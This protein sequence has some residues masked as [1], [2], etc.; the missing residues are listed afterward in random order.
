MLL[1]ASWP[2]LAVA[3]HERGLNVLDGKTYP[4][5]PVM[6]EIPQLSFQ[7]EPRLVTE[8]CGLKVPQN[9]DCENLCNETQCPPL[10]D[11]QTTVTRRGLV[12]SYSPEMRMRMGWTMKCKTHGLGVS[13]MGN[14][15]CIL[16]SCR[17]L[18]LSKVRS[19]EEGV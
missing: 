19:W 8:W 17:K 15:P 3:R 16:W 1:I 6:L 7:I 9:F 11:L 12:W 10:G 14:C 18:R 13:A 2:V 4:H 5:H